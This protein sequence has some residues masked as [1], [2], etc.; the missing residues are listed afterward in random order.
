LEVL[1]SPGAAA[2]T[3]SV[4]PWLQ[5]SAPHQAAAFAMT[6]IAALVTWTLLARLVRL[7][8]HATPLTL[9]D[10]TLGAGFGLLRGAV[11]L[12]VVA[13]VVALTPARGSAPWQASQGAVWLGL[14]LQGLKP[15]LPV[16]VA[17][18]LPA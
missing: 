16:D 3:P 17:R 4:A 18:Q 6:F 14:V 15:V 9:V 5:T 7:V 8:I 1:Q 12:L 2:A 10:R 13:T 11:L